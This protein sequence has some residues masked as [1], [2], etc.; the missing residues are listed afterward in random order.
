MVKLRVIEVVVTMVDRMRD[1]VRGQLLR[2][3][4]TTQ[5]GGRGTIRD[6]AV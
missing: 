1:V 2:T 6:I 3:L 5:H 4:A